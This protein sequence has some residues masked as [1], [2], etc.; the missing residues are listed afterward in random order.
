[1]N[2]VIAMLVGFAMGVLFGWALL[3]L[4]ALYGGST[5]RPPTKDEWKVM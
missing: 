2:I 1:M 3:F 5:N 4:L